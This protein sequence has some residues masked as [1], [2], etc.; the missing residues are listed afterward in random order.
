MACTVVH[1]GRGAL[2]LPVLP[3]DHAG[4][5]HGPGRQLAQLHPGRHAAGWPWPA[6]PSP[7]GCRGTGPPAS[8]PAGP[9][10]CAAR[11][12]DGRGVVGERQVEPVEFVH[13]LRG[14]PVLEFL[15]GALV[16]FGQ[17]GPGRVIQ[18]RAL[19]LV[20]QLLDHGA[21]AHDLGRLVHQV[22]HAGAAVAQLRHP[23]RRIPMPAGGRGAP[24]GG[25]AAR[26]RL[27]TLALSS[28]TVGRGVRLL[29]HTA[30]LSRRPPTVPGSGQL[31]GWRGHS[32]ASSSGPGGWYPGG[33]SC[34]AR[35][36]YRHR[37]LLAPV[38]RWCSRYFS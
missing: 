16:D 26:S 3:H 6:P 35:T 14:Q 17:P 1:P 30:S 24:R 28:Q 29:S 15:D 32:G 33:P 38:A 31:A 10:R 37:R 19:H 4:G 36:P 23:A 12:R 34:P 25:D 13:Q 18:R 11:R 22:G 2:R 20:Q 7:S 5:N 8:R 21:D 9:G 27:N